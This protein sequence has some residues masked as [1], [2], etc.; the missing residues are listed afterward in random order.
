MP[1]EKYRKK[2]VVVEA[3]QWNIDEK[4]MKE[5]MKFMNKKTVQLSFGKLI[6]D[7]LE[8]KMLVGIN[9]WIIKGIKGEFYPCEPDVFEKTYEKVEE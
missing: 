6:I 5:V 7:T 2:P 8:G 3:I 1:V 4:T 9:D